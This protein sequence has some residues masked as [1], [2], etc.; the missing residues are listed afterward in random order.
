MISYPKRLIE[1]DFP[2][3]R[4][5]STCAAREV[6]RPHLL[7]PHLVGAASAGGVS[8][9]DLRSTLAGPGGS[10][11]CPPAFIVRAAAEHAI[12]RLRRQNSSRTPNLP[13]N[14]VHRRTTRRASK[15]VAQPSTLNSQPTGLRT[16]LTSSFIADF[17]NWDNSTVGEYLETSRALTQAAHEALGGEPSTRPLVVDP[18]AGGGS[19]PLEALRV[20]GRLW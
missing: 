8:R 13:T 16:A 9:G 14:I 6:H 11:L 1:V 5:F 7:T 3:M 18:F 19:I 15:L 12:R 10:K 20:G 17:A 2:I 4:I